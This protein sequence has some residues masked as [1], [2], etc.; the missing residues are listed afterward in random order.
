M[1][2]PQDR[3]P[4]ETRLLALFE[5]LADRDLGLARLL[6]RWPTEAWGFVIVPDEWIAGAD[7]EDVPYHAVPDSKLRERART[8]LPAERVRAPVGDGILVVARLQ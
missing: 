3:L 6:R 1:P 5:E 2:F 7:A 8:L 4:N